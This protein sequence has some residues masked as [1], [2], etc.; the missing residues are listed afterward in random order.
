V[1]VTGEQPIAVEY[2]VGKGGSLSGGVSFGGEINI[3]VPTIS[4]SHEKFKL[5]L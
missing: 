4:E 1:E 3:E 5:G 2:G